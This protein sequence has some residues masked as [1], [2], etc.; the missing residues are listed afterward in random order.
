[1][2]MLVQ[3]KKKIDFFCLF[4]LSETKKQGFIGFCF[5]FLYDSKIIYYFFMYTVYWEY[6][7][8]H[9]LHVYQTK[10]Y[11]SMTKTFK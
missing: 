6:L 1:M 4:N 7:K 8:F 10:Y 2:I 11:P 3:Y 9:N 5:I